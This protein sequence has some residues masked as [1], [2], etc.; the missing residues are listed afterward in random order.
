MS[1]DFSHTPSEVR[2][3]IID[4]LPRNIVPF[5]T[6]A[7]GLGKSAIVHQVA[8]EFNLELIDIRLSQCTPEDLM[9]LP[10]KNDA[11]TRATFVPFD[12]FPSEST[13]LPKGKDGWLIFLDEFNS[14][15]RSVLAAAYKVIWDRMVGMEKLH[16]NT[17]VVLAGN[18]EEDNAIVNDIGTA[19]QSR[20]V[21]LPM[22]KDLKDFQANAYK[23]GFDH[24]V[25]GFLESQP[26]LLHEFDPDHQNLTF[27]C[28]RTW[29][30][31]SRFIEGKSFD[32]INIKTLSG[33][34]SQGPATAFYAFLKEAD[35]IPKL[36][37]ILNNPDTVPV[38]SD[39]GTQ[40]AILSMLTAN[41][42]NDNFEDITKYVTR[43]PAE[44]Q[45]VFFRGCSGRD[46]SITR[47]DAFKK[48]L[49]DLKEFIYD[50]DADEDFSS[51]RSAA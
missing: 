20:V 34:I 11:G 50:D 47:H 1:A 16:E 6:S 15:T 12:T 43:M 24:R 45:I 8:E 18:R 37:T 26:D 32:E 9:G 49:I 28:P 41:F 23:K 22:E 4:L 19:L 36:K 14:A 27:A 25:M 35:R 5:I 29:E 44:M 46:K 31:A 40:F 17:F 42:T 3:E 39:D 30:L 2:K 38:P 33:I 13:P 7:P 48:A 51:I 21:I 10:M